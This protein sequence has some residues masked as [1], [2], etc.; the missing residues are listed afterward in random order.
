MGVLGAMQRRLRASDEEKTRRATDCGLHHQRRTGTIPFRHLHHAASSAGQVREG[1]R[2]SSEAF[3]REYTLLTVFILSLMLTMH[4]FALIPSPIYYILSDF[5]L[6][7][8]TAL[9]TFL[10]LLVTHVLNSLQL[11]FV[12]K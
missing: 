9:S 4:V 5:F 1:S 7:F 10:N 3:A 8:D 11:S 12:F 2:Q 6:A